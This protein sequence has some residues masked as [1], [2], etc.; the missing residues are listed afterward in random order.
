MSTT[1]TYDADG[2]I[3]AT[4]IKPNT[5]T[6]SY[7]RKVPR[8]GGYG[9]GEECSIFQQVDVGPDD[10]PERVEAAVKAAFAFSK[11]VVL[12][13]LGCAY[14]VDQET[15]VVNGLDSAAASAAAAPA[16]RA[17]TPSQSH[18]GNVTSAKRDY[19]DGVKRSKDQ[20]IAELQSNPGQFF[21]NRVDKKNPKG[22][23]FKRKSSG[24]GLWLSDLE[25]A[26]VSV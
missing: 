12:Q 20:L 13:Q 11:A 8:D 10:S 2:V 22:P 26:G 17:T 4:E 24:E 23:D 21:D 14:G 5:V 16:P 15:G 19:G 18:G 1:N 6:I 7:G 9:S 3:T 25:S